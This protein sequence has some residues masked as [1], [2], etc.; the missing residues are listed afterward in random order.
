MHWKYRLRVQVPKWP[1]TF[2]VDFITEIVAFVPHSVYNRQK[3]IGE[4]IEL[5]KIK[6]VQK[7]TSRFSLCSN[8]KWKCD[9]SPQKPFA[10]W[11]LLTHCQ[12]VVC[13]RTRQSE[14]LSPRHEV[15][16]FN[17]WR[18]FCYCSK[19]FVIS[20]RELRKK[21]KKIQKKYIC[22]ALTVTSFV[23]CV[24]LFSLWSVMFWVQAVTLH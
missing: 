6:S 22:C 11:K 4:Y 3:L 18:W 7:C 2:A 9:D 17:I 1:N 19:D 14:S 12:C 23:S 13:N 20:S 21:K 24:F 8:N 16:Y 15:C 10:S 5:R